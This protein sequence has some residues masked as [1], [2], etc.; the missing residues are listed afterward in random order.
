MKLKGALLAALALS[1]IGSLG[2][3]WLTPDRLTQAPDITLTTLQGKEL[4][5]P[6]PQGGPLLVNFWATSCPGCLE[7][8]PHLIELYKE[9]APRGFEVIGIAMAY[10]PPN[11]VIALSQS[12]QIPYP[13]ALDIQGEAAKA[14]GNVSLTPSSFLIA[15]DGRII[16]RQTGELELN[17]VRSLVVDMLA[18]PDTDRCGATC[19]APANLTRSPCRSG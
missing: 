19:R 15:P 17:K 18:R 2:L 16:R 6:I 12:K 7:E 10:D 5:I 11:R 14:F 8:I 9:L 13:I 3:W 1:L 4:S